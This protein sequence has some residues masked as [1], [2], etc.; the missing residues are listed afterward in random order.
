MPV[1]GGQRQRGRDRIHEFGANHPVE[2][3]FHGAARRRFGMAPAKALRL[4]PP[5]MRGL[6]HLPLNVRDLYV[7]DGMR[8]C[9]LPG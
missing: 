4:G 8:E 2:L 9:R 3:D 1:G 6:R 7:D 5:K